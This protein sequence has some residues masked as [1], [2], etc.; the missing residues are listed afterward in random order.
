MYAVLCGAYNARHTLY[1]LTSVVMCSAYV[2]GNEEFVLL[3]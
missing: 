2:H 1:G 3:R